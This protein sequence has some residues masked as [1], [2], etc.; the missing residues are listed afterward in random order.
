MLVLECHPS[1]S[2]VKPGRPSSWGCPS[3]LNFFL[4]GLLPCF[5]IMPPPSFLENTVDISVQLPA[6]TLSVDVANLIHEYF[7]GKFTVKSIQQRPGRIARVSFEEPEARVAVEELMRIELNGVSCPVVVPLPP[8]PRY[9]NVFVYLYPYESSDQPIVDFCSHYGEVDSVRHQ[10]W[11]NLPEVSTGTRIVRMDRRSHIPRLVIINGFRCKVWY[12][13]QPLKCDICSGDHKAASCPH[14]GKCIRCGEK[15]HFARDCRNPW[16]NATSARPAPGTSCDAGPTGDPSA[17]QAAAHVEPDFPSGVNPPASDPMHVVVVDGGYVAPASGDPPS[18]VVDGVVG[19][20]FN[21][22]DEVISPA[23]Q[24][25][26]QNCS[27]GP[28]DFLSINVV[29]CSNNSNDSVINNSNEGIMHNTTSSDN[30][31]IVVDNNIPNSSNGNPNSICGAPN[32]RIDLSSVSNSNDLPNSNDS[33]GGANYYGSAVDSEMSVASD[34]R[35][36]PLS[37][38]SSSEEPIGEFST[39]SSG[40][41][42]AT[43]SRLGS[44]LSDSVLALASKSRLGANKKV[45]KKPL[46]H[47]PA[48]VVSANRLLPRPKR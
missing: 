25:I 4:F 27:A 38:A 35:K 26:L 45:A 12:K 30:N 10:H 1:G 39:D 11:T 9:S 28:I 3:G 34:P 46:G 33:V 15:G 13:G 21:Q 8:P 14:K 47:L 32:S 41:A 18:S 5:F 40:P 16:G 2:L 29:N 44:K 6:G 7:A 37:D 36:R 20:R 43:R 31:V 19:E 24:S 22:L 17:D 23:S 48:G 42:P